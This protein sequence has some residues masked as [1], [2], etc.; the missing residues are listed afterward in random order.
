MVTRRKS[1]GC[2]GLG[3]CCSGEGSTTTALR[4]VGPRGQVLG[5]SGIPM[6]SIRGIVVLG[7]SGGLSK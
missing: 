6:R 5:A 4:G 7:G 2:R 3:C 1:A